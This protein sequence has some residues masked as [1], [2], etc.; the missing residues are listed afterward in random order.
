MDMTVGVHYSEVYADPKAEIWDYIRAGGSLPFPPGYQGPRNLYDFLLPLKKEGEHGQAFAYKTPNAEVLGWV[1][2]RASGRS[3]A[4]LLSEKLWQ[5][6]GAE[7]DAY[8]ATDSLGTATAGGGLAMTLR[9]LGRVG[10]VFR[11]GGRA[12]GQQ[13]VP[14][15]VVADIR[16]GGDK[17]HFAKAGYAT[18]PGWSYRDMWWVS[19]NEHGAFAMR[20]IHGQALWIDPKAEMVIARFASNPVAA[21]GA[22]DPISLP[23]YAAIAQHLMAAAPR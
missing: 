20:G 12:N 1:L 18:L 4:K 21:N 19:H 23:A 13:I 8:F 15:E 7:E 11:Q 6:L 14:A 17:A 3:T 22:N 2:Q 9:D 16:Q 10:E 5:K